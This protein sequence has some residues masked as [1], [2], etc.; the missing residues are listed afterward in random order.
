MAVKQAVTAAP[1][2]RQRVSMKS[3]NFVAGGI[4]PEGDY[5]ITKSEF[6]LFQYQNKVGQL[7]AT[8]TAFHCTFKEVVRNGN[9]WTQGENEHEQYYSVGDPSKVVP[10]EDGN[11]IDSV[12]SST[13]LSNQSNYY[14]AYNAM[15]NAG[16]NEDLYD[17]QGAAML[18]GAIVHIHHIPAPDRSALRARN[19]AVGH[20]QAP[21]RENP[22]IPVVKTFHVA[23]W[24]KKGATVAAKVAAPANPAASKEPAA[25][26]A[27]S[28]GADN[29]LAKFILGV[30]NEAGG[31]LSQTQTR[32]K[33]H[34]AYNLA[35]IEASERDAELAAFNDE[36]IL[37][38]VLASV[39]CTIENGSIVLVQ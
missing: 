24:E 33:T 18:V 19:S 30:I 5:Q 23:P 38:D 12:T 16:L 10:S 1:V 13:T 28:N 9:T 34:R 15:V 26:A 21:V 29:R 27:E 39:N 25:V 14:I 35:K 20:Q 8:T 37:N 6:S 36:N 17:D 32:L 31:T 22:T 3:D 11:F 4:L 7:G 2:A